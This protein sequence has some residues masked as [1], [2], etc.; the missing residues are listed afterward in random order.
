V[1]RHWLGLLLAAA[2]ASCSDT[3]EL[4]DGGGPTSCAGVGRSRCVDQLSVG[5]HFACAALLDR[6]VWCWGRN[7][8]GQL[9]YESAE[10]C[11]ERLASGQTRPIACH[12]YP[13]QVSGVTDAVR[14]SAGGSHA[15]AVTS[16][17][18]V[19][20]WGGNAFGQLGNGASLPSPAAVAVTGAS[21]VAGVAVGARHACAVTR[22]GAVSCWGANDRGQL[23]VARASSA[24]ATAGG[25][26]VACERAP[27]ALQG[28]VMV[29]ELVAGDE[30]TCAR[31][32]A[33]RVFCWGTNADGELGNTMPTAAPTPAPQAVLFGSR[34][35][36]DV[37]SIVAGAHHTCAL[38][39]DGAVLCWGRA[40][41]GQL[42]VMV[43][44]GP[45]GGCAGP[46]VD[47]PVAVTGFEGSITRDDE[48]AGAPTDA[49]RTDAGRT[50]AGRTDAG[51]TDGATDAAADV[52]L[53][54]LPERSPPAAISAGGAQ[55]CARL[56]DSTV[57][58]WGS[59][60]VGELGSGQPGEGGFTPVTVIASPGASSSNPLQNVRSIESGAA[61]TC[62]ILADRSL[63]CWGSNA[64][65]ALGVGTVS[66]HLG[67]VAVTW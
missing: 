30:H 11:P 24:C 19:R 45:P 17:G 36:E 64:S 1:V 52:S 50:D 56:E 40:D 18:T 29:E 44:S 21:D 15:C 20:C 34:P 32:S 28:L 9:G 66:E 46:C 39:G 13:R 10:L 3:M 2:L 14:V 23:G 27:V 7:D 65:G 33:G 31:T 63:R 62:A 61:S 25:S 5:A 57:R 37:R 16:A 60:R 53:P 26:P 51:R 4:P 6:T 42:G 59:N 67:P 55:G 41:R 8:E 54:P 47:G 35:L 38:R 49:G 48:D 43:P 22:A 58:C 12:L